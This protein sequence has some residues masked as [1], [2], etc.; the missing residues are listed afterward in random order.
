M[1]CTF[2]EIESI[3]VYT[4][5]VGGYIDNCHRNSV[6]RV[7]SDGLSCGYTTFT[8]KISADVYVDLLKLYAV[9]RN[10]YKGTIPF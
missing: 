3:T 2:Y 7:L 9:L 8:T 5:Y 1:L 6:L 10:V 4:V